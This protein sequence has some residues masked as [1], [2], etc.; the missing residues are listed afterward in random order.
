MTQTAQAKLASLLAL[1]LAHARRASATP[2]VS[3]TLGD[4]KVSI[5]AQRSFST[6][7]YVLLAAREGRPTLA[8]ENE[9]VEALGLDPYRREDVPLWGNSAARLLVS[10][11][12]NVR[13]PTLPH[14]SPA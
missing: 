2:W 6:H 12:Y 14:R 1:T 8:Q 7:L 10:D 5:R 9:V 3:C 11:Q 13:T 4:L